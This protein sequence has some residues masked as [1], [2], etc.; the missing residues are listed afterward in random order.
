LINLPNKV[1]VT[2]IIASFTD[3]KLTIE[4][5]TFIINDSTV[6]L[7]VDG[8]KMNTLPKEASNIT[9][10]GSRSDQGLVAKQ[11]SMIT[12]DEISSTATQEP[13]A[14]AVKGKVT[15]KQAEPKSAQPKP[16]ENTSQPPAPTITPAPTPSNQATGTFITE[17]SAPQYIP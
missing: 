17:P 10:V 5:N 4:K 1:S 15:P 11:I 12:L 13:V 6:I 3:K 8:Q 14:P 2:G 7:D 16:M 9:V